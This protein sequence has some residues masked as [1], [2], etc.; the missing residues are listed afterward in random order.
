[1][2]IMLRFA[3]ALGQSLATLL[4]A[5]FSKNQS[6]SSSKGFARCPS[7]SFYI[8]YSFT[9]LHK[10]PLSQMGPHLFSHNIWHA[11]FFVH[12]GAQVTGKNTGDGYFT[13]GKKSFMISSFQIT[14]LQCKTFRLLLTFQSSYQN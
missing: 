4:S 12:H 10:C 14:Y 5:K 13:G 11:L 7:F 8:L 3:W 1:M 9:T 6:S 2:C